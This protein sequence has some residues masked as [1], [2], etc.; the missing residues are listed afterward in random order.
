[1][2]QTF[3][4]NSKGH[5]RD[6]EPADVFH[7]VWANGLR[8]YA[9]QLFFHRVDGQQFQNMVALLQNSHPKS[10]EAKILVPV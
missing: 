4:L 6:W 3:E 9:L 2:W 1:L 7:F 5:P 10:M 8:S